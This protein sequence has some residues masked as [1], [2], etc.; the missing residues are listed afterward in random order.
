MGSEIQWDCSIRLC[1]KSQF[2]AQ[3]KVN[4]LWDWII[5]CSSIPSGNYAPEV[6]DQERH[7]HLTPT[8]EERGP[9][10]SY[11]LVVQPSTIKHFRD[12]LQVFCVKSSSEKYLKL[13]W[14]KKYKVSLWD[15]VEQKVESNLK[16]KYSSTQNCSYFVLTTA[17][18]KAANDP[19]F[20]CHL[21]L[22]LSSL[23]PVSIPPL[24]CVCC[25]TCTYKTRIW[26]NK[27]SWMRSQSHRPSQT[28]WTW[29]QSETF[30]VL[31][32]R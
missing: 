20:H 17:G 18:H 28:D 23:Q 22:S 26:T 9:E 19:A 29:R 24:C 32:Q 8:E 31:L 5:V 7:S 1:P 13:L 21:T 12:S 30:W 25:F 16:W 4:C 10:F 2:T 27:T 3:C 6:L 15:V 14:S 11:Y